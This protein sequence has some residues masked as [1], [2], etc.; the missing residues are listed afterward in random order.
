MHE[1]SVLESGYEYEDKT[2]RSLTEVAKVITGSKR[3]GPV[4]FGLKARVRMTVA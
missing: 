2:Y 1:V 3:S 4:F